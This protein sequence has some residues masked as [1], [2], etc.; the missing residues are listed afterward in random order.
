[1]RFNSGFK[2][3][4]LNVCYARRDEPLWRAE[5]LKYCWYDLYTVSSSVRITGYRT[6]LRDVALYA[7]CP[8]RLERGQNFVAGSSQ[9]HFEVQIDEIKNSAVE[10]TIDR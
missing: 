8:F 5:L 3:L 7:V 4:I 6:G 10:H 2:G 9:T 1:M